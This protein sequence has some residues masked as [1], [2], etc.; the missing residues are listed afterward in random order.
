MNWK[1]FKK[2]SFEKSIFLKK[3][4][5]LYLDNSI[6]INILLLALTVKI[7]VFYFLQRNPLI[8]VP[9][10]EASFYLELSE[11][12]SQGKVDLFWF[13]QP[14]FLFL[15]Y[16]FKKL[17]GDIWLWL[18]AF[19]SILSLASLALIYL[20]T[21]KMFDKKVALL[22]AFFLSIFE[23]FLILNF[24][25]LPLTLS[26]FFI[27]LLFNIVVYEY[28]R[29]DFI[30]YPIIGIILFLLATL[31]FVY[32]IP[33]L[34]AVFLF[35]LERKG[36]LKEKI[37]AGVFIIAGASLIFFL[38][39][40]SGISSPAPGNGKTLPVWIVKLFEQNQITRWDLPESYNSIA[41]KIAI[42]QA[43]SDQDQEQK[44]QSIPVAVFYL[45]KLTAQIKNNPAAFLKN[46][47]LK[48]ILIF[49]KFDESPNYS[50]LQ[51]SRVFPYFK[52]M[53][54]FGP[55]AVLGILGLIFGLKKA[56][57]E[58]LK[59]NQ[60]KKIAIALPLFLLP[61]LIIFPFAEYKMLIFLPL[62]IF[63]AFFIF[64][65]INF[66]KSFAK[67]PQ[68]IAYLLLGV[69]FLSYLAIKNIATTPYGQEAVFANF[70]SKEKIDNE[71][72]IDAEN[73]LLA[74][75]RN[76]PGYYP[77][78]Q[79]LFELYLLNGD[80]I[81]S[82]NNLTKKILLNPNDDWNYLALKYYHLLEEKT[83]EDARKIYLEKPEIEI[84]N[85]YIL[86]LDYHN[87]VDQLEKKDIQAAESE[88]ERLAR[89]D[90]KNKEFLF[91]RIGIANL[92][93]NNPKKAE[94][95]FQKAVEINPYLLPAW[96][97]LAEIN[98]EEEKYEKAVEKL[99]A[100]YQEIPDYG[101]IIYLIADSYLKLEK[102]KEALPFMK[103]F[104]AKN[105]NNP[106]SEKEVGIFEGKILV[107]ERE[108]QEAEKATENEQ[109]TN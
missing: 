43:L 68:K 48:F 22:S 81:T 89:T 72:F 78:Y 20:T 51:Y 35:S 66:I 64:C 88:F 16:F 96:Y 95:F 41:E 91:F 37:S 100:I 63:S 26:I 105:R 44:E 19:Q 38:V 106:Q 98:F 40:F 39:N 60:L 59:N 10:Q 8:T 9:V 18:T 57:W 25:L 94:N 102:E 97:N 34:L 7:I 93:N 109:K 56:F 99:L 31:D 27:L 28:P 42:Y 79:N 24:Q 32:S 29:K 33:A 14:A 52:F 12:I 90:S 85:Q 80:Y 62:I 30:K 61:S 49:N 103:E 55:F 54:G 11:K 75:E 73:L 5:S 3:A 107:L 15:I 92:L 53:P 101:N 45:E 17:S 65:F 70:I 77:T 21:K 71:E 69:V 74:T 104:V 82:K 47:G 46:I 76:Q 87:A 23:P 13:N 58:K 86:N 50:P 6:F 83:L 4:F 36:H 84:Q 1:N 108:A 2:K 67:N